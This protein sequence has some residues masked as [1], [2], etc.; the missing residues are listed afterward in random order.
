M[1]A[2][3]SVH[4]SLLN[5]AIRVVANSGVKKQFTN[6]TQANFLGV[7]QIFAAAIGPQATLHLHFVAVHWKHAIT[8]RLASND[9]AILRLVAKFLRFNKFRRRLGAL[10]KF[11]HLW[12]FKNQNHAGHSR[13][14]ARGAAREDHVH[15]GAT[16]QTFRAALAQ[17]P[18]HGVHD[19]ALAATIGSD[20]ARQRG[21]K[22]EFGCVGETFETAQYKSCKSHAT[23][24][25]LRCVPP[26]RL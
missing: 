11:R 20:H 6:V 2:Q 21:I 25:Q 16:A 19:I 7:H 8:H 15:H 26:G 10:Q 13:R 22:T 5:N 23:S 9:F 4:F 14:L 18:F 12:I 24:C 3:H 17:H 1:R